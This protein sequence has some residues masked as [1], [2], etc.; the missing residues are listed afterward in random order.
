MPARPPSETMPI[1]SSISRSSAIRCSADRPRRPNA[2]RS[3]RTS[4]TCLP[5][6]TR[7]SADPVGVSSFTPVWQGSS[8]AVSMS[9]RPA[10]NRVSTCSEPTSSSAIPVQPDGTMSC[11]RYSSASSP[12]ADALTRSGMSLD[13]RV[14]RRPSAARFSAQA[15]MRESFV[16]LRNPA[17][18]TIGSVWLSSTCRVP[19]VIA[20]RHRRVQPAVLDAQVVQHPQGLPGEVPELG[21]VPFGLQLADHH[22]R[23]DR[24]VLGELGQGPGIGQQHRGVDDVGP[25]IGRSAAGGTA[26][27]RPSPRRCAVELLG[28]ATCGH[29]D[30]PAGV[31]AGRPEREGDRW[32]PG[33]VGYCRRPR[34][35]GTGPLPCRTRT[36]NRGL[37]C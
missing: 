37:Q 32:T 14:T 3:P 16:S 6:V 17:G 30:S 28:G 27:G 1:S 9:T 31:G 22:Q 19:A 7:P 34:G 29:E 21:M 8:R 35:P 25:S 11:A 4:R 13:T 24:L 10:W 18:S 5:G 23:Q 20:D 36:I 2:S 15:R 12:T 26:G 33:G